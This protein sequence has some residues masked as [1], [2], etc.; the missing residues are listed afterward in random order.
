MNKMIAIPSIRFLLFS[1]CCFFIFNLNAQTENATL[2]A[3]KMSHKIENSQLVF[4]EGGSLEKRTD[5][6]ENALKKIYV[7]A[8]YINLTEVTNQ[9]YR[10]FI[11]WSKE[12]QPEKLSERLP[13]TTVWSNY[14]EDKALCKNLSVDYFRKPAFDYFPVVGVSW[15]Q[16]QDFLSWKSNQVNKNSLMEAGFWTAEDVAKYPIFEIKQYLQGAYRLN[17]K[18]VL[19][20]IEHIS[21]N[22]RL[23]T[24]AEWEFAALSPLFIN[25]KKASEEEIRSA[26]NYIFK[27]NPTSGKVKY[28]NKRV[29]KL[30]RQVLKHQK[31]HP[32]PDYYSQAKVELPTHVFEG[33]LND[34]GLF[35]MNS[36]SSE[37]VQDTYEKELKK[38][39]YIV[40][41][42]NIQQEAGTYAPK[43]RQVIKEENQVTYPL[44]FR[45]AMSYI[46]N[47]NQIAY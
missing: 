29:R 11:A 43:M 24:E 42:A 34:F 37:W 7:S 17:R 33:D 30:W 32:L 14:I 47:R 35:N 9:E 21:P 4:I 45:A 8:F 18:E 39:G 19:E 41:G 3:L 20:S 12:Y 38:T 16:A 2:E 15:Q 36:N 40:K 27:Y 1:L 44:G 23:P 26:P 46:N 13:D 22:Y 28:W 10:E 6:T 5:P 31:K 25:K